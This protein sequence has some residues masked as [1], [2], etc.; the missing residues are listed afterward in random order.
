MTVKLRNLDLN[1]FD[2]LKVI[3]SQAKLPLGGTKTMACLKAKAMV[4]IEI[5][6]RCHKPPKWTFAIIFRKSDPVKNDRC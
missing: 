4:K 6:M 3:M 1:E 5:N 2:S